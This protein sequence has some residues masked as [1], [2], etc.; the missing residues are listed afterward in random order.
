MFLDN[1][2]KLHGL[3]KTVVSD[4]GPQLVSKFWKDLCELSEIEPRLSS[5]FHPETD[6]QTERVNGV[7]EQYLRAYVSYQQDDW[8]SRL[9]MTEFST[10]NHVSET[11][12]QSPFVSN[13]GFSPRMNEGLGEGAGESGERDSVTF[14]ESLASLHDCLRAEIRWAQDQYEEGANASR[15][16]APLFKVVDEVWLSAKNIR[17]VRPAKMLDHKRLGKFKIIQVVSPYAYK[18]KLPRTMKIHPVFHVS[19]LERVAEDPIPG[20]VVV[21]PPPVVIEGQEE[22]EV[23]QILDSRLFRRRPQYLVKWLG[24]DQ[25]TWEPPVCLEGAPEMIEEFHN[26]YPE[27]PGPW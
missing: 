11:T 23:E 1:V 25:T 17:T 6:G 7:M 14:A 13:F 5:A 2:G 12:Q 9:S 26:R 18:L 21:P 15:I 3:P 22:W 24:Y 8:A 20:Q 27:K 4:R 16:P 19:I 10:N